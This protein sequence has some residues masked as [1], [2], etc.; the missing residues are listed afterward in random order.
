MK[1]VEKYE[2]DWKSDRLNI[3]YE[4]AWAEMLPFLHEDTIQASRQRLMPLDGFFITMS[5]KPLKN[6]ISNKHFKG[7]LRRD[8][9]V[10]LKKAL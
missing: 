8:L 3:L 6:V 9:L 1:F 2:F 4:P 7:L 5:G 10:L